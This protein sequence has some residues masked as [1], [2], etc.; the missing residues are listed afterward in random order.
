MCMNKLRAL[1]IEDEPL[2]ME[3]L[4][5]YIQEVDFVTVC[6]TCDSALDAYSAI[7]THEP[8]LIFLDIQM[9]KLTGI[10]FLKTLK[11]PPMVIFTT[12]Y[13]NY[14]LQ[15]FELD[16]VDYLVKPYPFDRFLK[17]V[18]KARELQQLQGRMLMERAEK[19]DHFYVKTDH[20]YERINF[21]DILYIEGM[22]NYVS[23]HTSKGRIITMMTMKSVEETLIDAD[24]IRIHKTYIVAIDK[25]EAIDG[26]QV[27]I[28]G[29][30]IPIS[31][32]RK[33]EV[34][35]KILKK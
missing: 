17:A 35:T 12:A 33:N 13:H 31:R 27:V 19:E 28:A 7:E 21:Q 10:D 26:N 20:R 3:G 14:A 1:I 29:K 16:V 11:K 25:I 32:Q 30:K 8:D 4:K 22:E 9:P 24:F 23:I 15:G 6:E 2:A 34:L 5:S 18:N